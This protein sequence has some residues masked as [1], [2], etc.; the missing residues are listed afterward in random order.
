MNLCYDWI[1]AIDDT[2]NR[3]F[4]RQQLDYEVLIVSEMGPWYFLPS[5]LFW[6]LFPFLIL[7]HAGMVEANA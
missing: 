1:I 5:W 3:N 4:A 2:A 6:V 7:G